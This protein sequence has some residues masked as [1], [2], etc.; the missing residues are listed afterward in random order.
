MLADDYLLA[1]TLASLAVSRG[2]ASATWIMT[3]ALARY[4]HAIGQPQIY[5]TQFK[6]PAATQEP[7]D[8]E[9]ISDA[10]RR[11]LGVPSLAAQV[12]QQRDFAKQF[13]SP[14]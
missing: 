10:L 6:W 5:G 1:H 9:L 12:E 14:K 7:F 2:D 13:A 3:A 8:R 11:E 4:L